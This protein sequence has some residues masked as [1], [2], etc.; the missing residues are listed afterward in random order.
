[1]EQAQTNG[2]NGTWTGVENNSVFTPVASLGD[3]H[4]AF[5]EV[6]QTTA[7]G[8][9]SGTETFTSNAGKID[10]AFTTGRAFPAASV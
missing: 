4:G 7:D 5:T 10:Q 9:T 3:V 6:T 1:M 8:T 2:R